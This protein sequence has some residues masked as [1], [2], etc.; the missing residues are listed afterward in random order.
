VEVSSAAYKKTST[1]FTVI[2]STKYNTV[3][4]VEIVEVYSIL[5]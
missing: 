4:V 5:L 2:L 3:E 1:D